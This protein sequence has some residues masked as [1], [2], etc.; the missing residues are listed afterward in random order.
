MEPPLF[1][2]DGEMLDDDEGL[3]RAIAA[4]LALIQVVSEVRLISKY[5]CLSFMNSQKKRSPQ[6]L[7]HLE[8]SSSPAD[9]I[10]DPL[11]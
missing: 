9:S 11:P 6:V 2:P 5:P 10:Q 7:V 1:L 3:E 4:S 8:L